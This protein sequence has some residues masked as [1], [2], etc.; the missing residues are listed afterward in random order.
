MER[1]KVGIIG[2]GMA[3]EKLH[4][5]VYQELEKN[6]EIV[7]LC[8]EDR[9]K[10]LSWAE[11][12]GVNLEKV[13]ADYRELAKLAELQIIDIMVPISQNFIVTEAVAQLVAG[14]KKAIIC[15]KPLAP[16]LEQA[17][18]AVGLIEKYQVPIMIAENYRYNED[19]KLIKDL[20]TEGQI[21]EVD[22]FLWNR[23]LNFPDDMKRDAFS[24]KEWRQHPDF[25]GGVFY[26]T[27]VHDLAALRYIFGEINELT[28]YG[29]HKEITLG[30]FSIVNVIFRFQSGFTGSYN[31]YTAGKEMQRPLVGLRIMG[32]KGEIYQEER[33]SG[34]INLA[35]N[36]GT[37]KQYPYR[38]QRGYYNE[39]LNLYH[40]Y[41]GEEEI[42]VTPKVEFGDAKT[43]LAILE[44][45]EEETPV[46]VDQQVD[47][48]YSEHVK[49]KPEYL[50]FP[51][52]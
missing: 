17:Q 49:T 51:K 43:A 2:T 3:F 35:L 15:E 21:G 19:P 10:A 37:K 18:A 6:Y 13:Y 20:I 36:D 46:K 40:A 4:Y 24:A 26:D 25:P 45:I 22:Y 16:N 41:L 48:Y 50:N 44:S 7:A 11:R 1:L 23:V 5:P 38:P 12:L 39:L 32:R 42:A 47:F 30:Q 9:S 29:Q 28:A 27:A 52:S 8:N 14:K 31:F 33:D 34:T